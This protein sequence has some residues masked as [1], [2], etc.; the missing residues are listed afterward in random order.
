MSGEKIFIDEAGDPMYQ[1][2][3]YRRPDGASLREGDFSVETLNA[4]PEYYA[5]SV[6]GDVACGK[7]LFRPVP[8]N[9]VCAYVERV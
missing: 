8:Q 6:A 1:Y 9:G 5:K 7:L 2:I 4:S 3:Y